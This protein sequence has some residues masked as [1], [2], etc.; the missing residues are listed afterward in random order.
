[1]AT[2]GRRE[3]KVVT[4]LFAD[5]VGFTARAEHLDPEDV[6]A[7][8][9][10]Y[11][12]RLRS[13]LER[14]GG[15]VEKFVGDAV[16]A[17]FGAPV[18]HED[19]PERAVRAALAVRDWIREEGELEVR[20]AVNTG[21]A[22][23]SLG[24]RLALG[25]SL[26]AGDVVNT[27]SRLQQAA[28]VNG[29]LVGEATHRATERVIRYE[30]SPAVEA[31]GK[32]APVPVWEAVEARSRYGVDVAPEPRTPL[33]GRE[34]ELDLLRA[35]FAR[36]RHERSPQLV[37]L[38]GVPGIGKTRLLQELFRTVE[39]D[40]ELIYWRQG[41]CL[42]YG[43]GV[44]LWALGEIVK[45]HAGILEGEATEA[46][47]QK[48]SVIVHEAVDDERDAAWIERHLRSLLGL[49]AD[50][51][52]RGD[53]DERFAAWRRFFEALAERSPLVLVFEDLHWADEGLLDFVDHLVD[54]TAGVPLLVVTAARPELMTR[55][56]NWGGGKPNAAT[57][58]L[59]PL[60]D[61]ETAS[62]VHGLLHRTV[63]PAELQTV[64]VRRS[65]GNPLYAEEFAR[66]AME[67]GASGNGSGLPMP[68]TVQGLIAARL[69]SLT[70]NDKS[71]LQDAAVVGRVF[72]VGA[73]MALGGDRDRRELEDRLHGLARKEFLRRERRSV[74]EGDTQYAFSHVLVRDVAYAQIP[75]A[76][77]AEKHEQAARWIEALGRPEEHADLRAHHYLSA[78]E[79][80]QTAGRQTPALVQATRGALR[81]AG[82][83]AA[84]LN[85][86]GPAARAFD[87]ALELSS[88]DDEDRPLLLF[89]AA[90]ARF[91]AAEWS[92]E[93]LTAARD[94]LLAK[95]DV[96]RAAQAETLAARVAW[97]QGRGD[98]VVQHSERA[99]ELA[100]PLPPAAEK[101]DVYTVLAR[102]HWLGNRE[103]AARRLMNQALELAD[104]LDLPA[105]RA[106]LLSM[107]GTVQATQGDASGFEALEQ[108]IAIYEELGSPDAQ[109]P[110]NNLADTLYRL[111][112]IR[113]AGE[114]TAR[115]AEAQKRYPGRVDF[116]RW[117]DT[118]EIRLHYAGGR[119]DRALELAERG[120]AELGPGGRH[121][122]EPEWRIFRARIRL[123]RGDG[124]GA[125]QDAKAAVERAREAG[126]AQILTPSLAAQ[127]RVLWSNGRTEAERV[128]AE[129]LDVCLRRPADVA[130]DWFPE[131]VLALVGLGR[132]TDIA[133]LAEKL[134]TP[135][136]WL[137]AGL[138]LGDGKP[139]LAAEI[140][141][142]MGALPF[143]AEARLLAAR[144]GERVGLDEAIT[145]F[146]RVRASALV[147]EA[148]TLVAAS[149]SA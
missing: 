41:R 67:R 100:A 77:R 7:I 102:L 90:R 25:E 14:F 53:Q 29:I 79:A 26:V 39:A 104:E 121:Y 13:E 111:G 45:A 9:R 110:Y 58:S 107:L 99:E 130:S 84:A 57:V 96:A 62:L 143:E 60:D 81:E 128:A 11:H 139:A 125:E 120:W 136:P 149:R 80:A 5:L 133:A 83:R 93:E 74:V 34:R 37:T 71:L 122:L 8:L 144:T 147:R 124:A 108:S 20:V 28:P 27:A 114:V 146:R 22:L 51:E 112:R 145:F 49:T 59:A 2:Q 126:D 1:M 42:P 50:A 132:A 31:K 15:T 129:L 86:Y 101:A 52:A 70:A 3:R 117:K 32:S 85:A 119:W 78:L 55:R 134:H 12:A 118:Q 40:P 91:D 142:E 23:V 69:D 137:D 19:D 97:M 95:G 54:W 38:I 140:F 33:V 98:E 36:A 73:A 17:V 92:I 123:A 148:E 56:P 88:D 66:V 141:A 68:E 35:A 105:V 65:G 47:A 116:A 10:P 82:E 46:A 44:A 6:E 43:D 113:E 127:A 4:V 131:A 109:S 89:A 18:A 16:L 48:L 24:A 115:M 138:A 63:L 94:A 64:L 72:W 30:N 103:S 106:P 135:T 87:R 75:R 61:E 76:D 21:E